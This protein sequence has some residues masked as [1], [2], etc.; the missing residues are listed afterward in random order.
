[1][2]GEISAHLDGRL[3]GRV[4]RRRRLALLFLRALYAFCQ[5][6]ARARSARRRFRIVRADADVT[7]PAATMLIIE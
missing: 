1:M 2:F 4:H 5:T 6:A 3:C 7:S